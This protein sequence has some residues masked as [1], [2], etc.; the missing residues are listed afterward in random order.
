[1][2][3]RIGELDNKIQ[4][5]TKSNEYY[6]K[7]IKSFSQTEITNDNVEEINNF[8]KVS[9]DFYNVFTSSTLEDYR[10]LKREKT[11]NLIFMIS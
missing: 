3:D 1:M 10:R 5:L 4:V 9:S 7:Q 2:I 8:F 11:Q 6:Q